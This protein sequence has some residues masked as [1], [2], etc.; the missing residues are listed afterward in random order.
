MAE[1]I[2]A[3]PNRIYFNDGLWGG[4]QQYALTSS[5][6][7]RMNR[8]ERAALIDGERKLRDGQEERWRLPDLARRHS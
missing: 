8:E 6:E 2:V 4:L 1:F 3:N 7:S 5:T